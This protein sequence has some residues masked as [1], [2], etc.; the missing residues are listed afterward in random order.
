MIS[1]LLV[2]CCPHV[3]YALLAMKEDDPEGALKAFHAIVAAEE[4]KGDW[5]V[6]ALN[7]V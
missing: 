7:K 3:Q 5:Y 4:E 1:T 6:C 2:S